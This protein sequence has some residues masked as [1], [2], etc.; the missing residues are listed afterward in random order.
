MSNGQS[1]TLKKSFRKRQGVSMGFL[2]TDFLFRKIFRQ[3]SGVKWAIH[4]TATIHCPENITRGKNVYPGDSP[5]VY[6]NALNGVRIGDYTN[7]GPNVGIVS[8]N[9]DVINN[10]VQVNTSPIDIGRFC[11]LGMGAVVLPGV[12]LGDF[13][14]VGAGA[15]VTKS[16]PEGYCVLAGNPAVII[17]QLNRSAC[18]VF[19]RSK[20]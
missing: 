11:W 19:A 4:H 8:A 1:H 20:T 10:E 13:T 16:F 18:E 2:I 14:I 6:I 12:V 9:H 7:I 17:K 5:G 15:I 3:N